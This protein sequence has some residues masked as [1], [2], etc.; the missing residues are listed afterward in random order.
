MLHIVE[1]LRQSPAIKQVQVIDFIDEA[2]VKYLKCRAECLDGSILQI[3]E[4]FIA[5]KNKYSYH[6]QDGQQRL[7]VRWD[8]APHHPHLSTFP[9]HRHESGA[10]LESLRVSIDDVLTE[11]E[12]RLQISK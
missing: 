3:E 1:A 11:I 12:T 5:S 10:V 9:H 8:N 7:L 6:W 2:T 4:S